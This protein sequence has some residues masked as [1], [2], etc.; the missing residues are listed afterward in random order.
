KLVVVEKHDLPLV[1][2]T[3]F[4]PGGAATDPAG[5]A[6]L[7]QLTASL[8]TKGT[9]TRSATQIAREVEALGGSIGSEAGWDSSFVS[10]DV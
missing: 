4:A 10:T 7:T 2:A 5:Q 3:V 6:G 1:A 8:L 9:A